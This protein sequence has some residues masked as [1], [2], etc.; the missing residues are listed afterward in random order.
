MP[1]DIPEYKITKTSKL[2]DFVISTN[3]FKSKGEIKRL[4]KQGAVKVDDEVIMDIHYALV[5]GTDKQ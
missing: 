3:S 1:D 5:H 4:I 2:V